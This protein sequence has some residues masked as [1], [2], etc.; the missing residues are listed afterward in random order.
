MSM[1]NYSDATLNR[2]RLR[3]V[4]K[5]C[6]CEPFK[7]EIHVFVIDIISIIADL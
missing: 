6:Y 5:I 7:H 1:S 4:F 2:D 3:D